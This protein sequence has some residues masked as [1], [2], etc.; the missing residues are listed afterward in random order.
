MESKMSAVTSISVV[1]RDRAGKGAARAT[2][3]QGLIPGVIYGNKLSPVSIA[4]NPRVLAVE[5]NKGGFL[6]RLF[7][8]SF[9]DRT[10][11]VLCRAVQRHPVSD[12][13]I[14]VDFLRI[15]AESQVHVHVPVHFINH[16]KSPGIKR[17]G[18][19]NVV[20]HEVEVIALAD[21]IPNELVIDLSGL[22]I[23]VS[24]HLSM[25]LLPAGTTVVTHE[26]DPTL[27]TIA[28]PTVATAAAGTGSA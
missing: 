25:V 12:Q 24:I 3:R 26:K 7:E 6:T 8:A 18:V 19:L 14:H 1:A 2:R 22:E 13:P 17:G 28:A 23:G 27:A 15:G 20:A 11:L 9:G 5:M 21:A 10:E 4:V 16:E